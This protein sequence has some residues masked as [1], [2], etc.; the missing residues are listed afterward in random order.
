M[1]QKLYKV[2]YTI[3]SYCLADSESDAYYAASPGLTDTDPL[4]CGEVEEIGPHSTIDGG[5]D[6]NCLVYH[7][8][9]KDT[10]LGSV[11]PKG[12]TDAG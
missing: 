5:W 1:A 9:K 6:E 11:W 3:V 2:T 12:K 10:K 4:D 8:G 7:E